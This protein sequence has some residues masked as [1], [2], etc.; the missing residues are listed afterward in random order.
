MPYTTCPTCSQSARRPA[1]LHVS[2]TV[3]DKLWLL[4]GGLC[5]LAGVLGVL[6]TS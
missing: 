1:R 2:L 6:V 4:A 5:V 3:T